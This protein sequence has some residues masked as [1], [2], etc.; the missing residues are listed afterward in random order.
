MSASTLLQVLTQALFV[1]VFVVVAVKAVRRTRRRLQAV[2]G[3]SLCLGLTILLAGISAALPAWAA[4]WTVLGNLLALASGLG[5]VIGF[6]PPAWL[7]QAWQGPELR[8]FLG[9]AARRSHLP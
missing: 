8:A 3:G 1:V 9:C 5:Y 7:R 2:A 6:A 4:W